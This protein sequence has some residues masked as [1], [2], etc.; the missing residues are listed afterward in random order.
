M[1]YFDVFGDINTCK[2]CGL[3][4][5]VA[6]LPP[7]EKGSAFGFFCTHQETSEEGS[8]YLIVDNQN[9]EIARID[10]NILNESGGQC[11]S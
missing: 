6:L 5:E 9:L 1:D 11:Q 10:W 7:N 3:Y 8:D 2:L 4:P